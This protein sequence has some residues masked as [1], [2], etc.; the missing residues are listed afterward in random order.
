VNVS[1][2]PGHKGVEGNERAD[3]EAKRAAT[4]RSSPKRTLSAQ[5]RSALPRSR[6]AAV[7]VFRQKLESRHDEQWSRSPRYQK[8]RDIDP[9][10]ATIASRRYWK[11]SRDLPRK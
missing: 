8:F 11:L 1:W 5:L 6:T 10:T 9:S 2:V 7:R 4:T 3:Q